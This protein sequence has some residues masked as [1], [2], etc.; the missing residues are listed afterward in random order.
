MAYRK[1]QGSDVSPATRITQEIITR[2]EAGTKR[3]SSRG[4]VSL[5]SVPCGPAGFPTA[6]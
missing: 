6:A 2:L 5:S 1:R 3:G 4:A